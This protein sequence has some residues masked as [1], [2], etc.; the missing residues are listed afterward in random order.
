MLRFV[1]S[2]NGAVVVSIVLGS[3]VTYSVWFASWHDCVRALWFMSPEWD[4]WRVRWVV[5]GGA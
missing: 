2:C 4:G 1:V 5:M 3:V